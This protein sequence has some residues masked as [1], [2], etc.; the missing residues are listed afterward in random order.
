[1][2]FS[3]Q[4][5]RNISF[6]LP[7]IAAMLSFGIT[8]YCFGKG[9]PV[10]TVKNIVYSI[11]FSLIAFG[12]A[13]DFFNSNT[14]LIIYVLS[15]F[16]AGLSCFL[17]IYILSETFYWQR[18]LLIIVFTTISYTLGGIIIHVTRYLATLLVKL[19]TTLIYTLGGI[20][21]DLITF[22]KSSINKNNVPREKDNGNFTI[23]NISSDGGGDVNIADGMSKIHNTKTQGSLNM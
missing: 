11:I 8:Y 6:S 1:M 19:F 12:M 5:N 20:M 15:G 17:A 3:E 21:G 22:Y 4:T 13:Q 7:F 9:M 16:L 10:D 2:Y 14:R 18:S 23:Y